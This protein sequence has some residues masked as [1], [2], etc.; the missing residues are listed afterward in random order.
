MRRNRGPDIIGPMRIGPHGS[1]PFARLRPFMKG[2]G[3]PLLAL[4]L[5]FATSVFAQA[6]RAAP[7]EAS[8]KAAFLYK[9]TAYVEWPAKAA[10]AD[11][12]FVVGVMDND[13]VAAE[14]EALAPGR[15]I[16]GRPIAVRRLARG[17]PVTGVQILF[18]GGRDPDATAIRSARKEGALVV[19]ESE[20]GLAAGSAINFVVAGD[21]VG[22][23][24]SL[25]GA[26]R[27]GVKISSRMLAVARRV[28]QKGS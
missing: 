8:V 25:D 19:T 13:A 4:L 22:F 5:T 9:F 3:R 7:S 27:S 16:G 11:Q 28:M 10:R 18:A 12:P 1:V 21:R 2:T 26:E 23:E 20:A 17:D 24:V 14:L 6:E 15:A